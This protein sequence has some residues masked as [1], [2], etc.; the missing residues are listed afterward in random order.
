MTGGISPA[1]TLSSGALPPGLTLS[2]A[3]VLS[4]TP[5]QGGTFN[6]TVRVDASGSFAT[7]AF[8]LTV[9][10]PAPSTLSVTGLTDTA[11]PA[12]QPT[13][14]VQ[15]SAAYPLTITGTVTLTFAPN[16]VNAADDPAIQFS[17][18]GRTLNF[19]IPAGQTQTPSRP[20]SHAIGTGTVAGQ[21][22]LTLE[23]TRPA[24]RTSRPR[25]RQR[26]S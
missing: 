22:N 18:G 20:P 5:T 15:L 8:S 25:R 9:T 7:K 26:A 2:T 1:W 17:G 10:V 23:I 19:S 16:A 24:A 6:F 21:I 11:T 3:G 4:G 14:D 12:Q 13:F